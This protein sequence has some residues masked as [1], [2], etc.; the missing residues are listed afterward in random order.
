MLQRYKEAKMA[1]AEAKSQAYIANVEKK[2]AIAKNK[3]ATLRSK[4]QI[5]M[6]QIDANA[7]QI[8]T[9]IIQ[10]AAGTQVQQPVNEIV[11]DS[12]SCCV[13]LNDFKNT[14][15]TILQCGHTFHFSCVKKL[16]MCPVCRIVL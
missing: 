5:A 10:N 2:I 11:Y 16:S 13:C 1:E 7:Y 8:Q 15:K 9:N 12:E 4:N 14:N 6:N 3:T